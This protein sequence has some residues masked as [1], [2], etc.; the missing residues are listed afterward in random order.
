MYAPNNLD[1]FLKERGGVQNNQILWDMPAMKWQALRNVSMQCYI[2]ILE[3][4]YGVRKKS[5]KTHTNCSNSTITMSIVHPLRRSLMR[6]NEGKE[7][8]L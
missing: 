1:F 4:Y 3:T 8:K 6:E 2:F 7:I 5:E